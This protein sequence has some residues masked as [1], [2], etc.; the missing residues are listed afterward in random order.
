MAVARSWGGGG[1]LPQEILE[2]ESVLGAI[3]INIFKCK[4]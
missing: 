1:A 2:N 4:F 3:F